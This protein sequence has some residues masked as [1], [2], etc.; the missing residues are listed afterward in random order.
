MGCDF[1]YKKN[2]F[3][4]LKDWYLRVVFFENGILKRFKKL[5]SRRLSR[6]LGKKYLSFIEGT[7]NGNIEHGKTDDQYL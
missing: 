1:F 3:E 6:F 2:E 7:R 5:N 4:N